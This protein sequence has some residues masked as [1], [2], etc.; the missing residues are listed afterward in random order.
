MASS[1]IYEKWT[2][3]HTPWTHC[4]KQQRKKNQI[5]FISI[6]VHNNDLLN[7]CEGMGEREREKQKIP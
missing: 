5:K 4:E 3:T 6:S 1:S 2:H 7:L